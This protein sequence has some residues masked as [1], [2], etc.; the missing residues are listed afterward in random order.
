[1]GLSE[2]ERRAITQ[3][4]ERCTAP[5]ARLSAFAALQRL[6]LPFRSLAF[7]LLA[8]FAAQR[9]RAYQQQSIVSASPERLVMNLYDLGIAACR[10]G[11]RA[12]VRA[13]LV[14]LI[15]G[16]NHERGGEL[17]GRLNALYEYALN[18][19]ALGELGVIEE[20]LSGLREAWRE[21]VLRRP[22]AVAA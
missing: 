11:D 10:Q 15:A 17:A 16:L 5:T 22:S 1:M 6:P 9:A 4:S 3:A 18:E 21:G 12:R 20:L 19:S 7:S 14:E 13:V 2:R 8:M